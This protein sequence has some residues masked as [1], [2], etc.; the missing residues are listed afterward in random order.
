MIRFLFDILAKIH[1][2]ADID[3]IDKDHHVEQ[4][5]KYIPCE[6]IPRHSEITIRDA[7]G[8]HDEDFI[9]DMISFAMVSYTD[10]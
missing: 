9:K 6:I 1:C 5:D 10:I 8:G 4:H 2:I 7:I 3:S